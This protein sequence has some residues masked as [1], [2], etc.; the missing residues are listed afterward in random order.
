MR[1][2]QGKGL[3]GSSQVNED[4]LLRVNDAYYL[5]CVDQL[6]RNSEAIE[7]RV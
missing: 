1:L 3:G 6:S 2:P 7:G 4:S 5:R